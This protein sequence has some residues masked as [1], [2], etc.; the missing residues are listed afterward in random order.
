MVNNLIRAR[1]CPFCRTLQFGVE[2]APFFLLFPTPF[3]YDAPFS[4][5]ETVVRDDTPPHFRMDI[6]EIHVRLLGA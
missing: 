2:N 1:E 6:P 5:D 4:Y 3:S